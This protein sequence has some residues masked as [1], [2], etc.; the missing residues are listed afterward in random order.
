MTQAACI[1]ITD[2]YQD[3]KDFLR[4]WINFPKEKYQTNPSMLQHVNYPQLYV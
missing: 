3:W 2:L 4:I 1:N